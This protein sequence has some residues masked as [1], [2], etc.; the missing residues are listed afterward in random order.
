MFDSVRIR[1]VTTTHSHTT[2][3]FATGGH[4][5]T[6]STTT[7]TATAMEEHDYQ[8]SHFAHMRDLGEGA[9]GEGVF[10]FVAVVVVVVVGAVVV[11]VVA[12]VVLKSVIEF[13]NE[14]VVHLHQCH[15]LIH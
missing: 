7:A 13:D 3:P 4:F 2:S 12:T 14:W 6:T 10:H 9:F 1:G 5:R 11:V 8:L 15:F